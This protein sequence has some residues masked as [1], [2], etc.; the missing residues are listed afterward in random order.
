MTWKKEQIGNIHQH[1]IKYTRRQYRQ[2]P[3]LVITV[4]DRGSIRGFKQSRN[5]LSYD[6][7]VHEENDPVKSS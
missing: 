3:E 4:A 5:Q 1:N 6:E 2:N 7:K